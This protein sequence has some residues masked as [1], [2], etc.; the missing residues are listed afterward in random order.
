MNIKNRIFLAKILNTELKYQYLKNTP[1]FQKND[2]LSMELARKFLIN[3]VR[4]SIFINTFFYGII[5][6]MF[7]L[8]MIREISLISTGSFTLFLLLLILAV[9]N[10]S[11]FYRGLWDMKLLAPLSSLPIKVERSVVPLSLFLYNES[12][13]PFVTIPAGIIITMELRNPLPLILYS[14]FT[15]LFLYMGRTISLLLGL[16]FAKTNTNKRSK[17]MYLGQIFQVVIFVIFIM[18]IQISTNPEFLGAI[19]VPVYAFLLIPLTYANL[20]VFNPYPFLIFFIL[21]SLI[22]SLYT[23]FQKKN[24]DENSNVY[25]AIEKKESRQTMKTRKPI[26]SWMVK[27][28]RIILRRRGSI[29]ILVI[30][31]TF[32]IPMIMSIST[33]SSGISQYEFSF[34]Y[35]SSIFLV[36]FILLIGLEGKSA[37]HLSALPVSRRDFFFSKVTLITIIGIF[38]YLIIVII[39]AFYSR[40]S[41]T[42][43]VLNFPYFI[44]ILLTVLMAGGA[45][46]ISAIPK[47]VYT[48]SQE[49]IGGRWILLKT[50]A[51]SL[52][53]IIINA[54]I[55]GF[56]GGYFSG[57]PSII[58]GY[59]FTIIFD[60]IISILFL[61]IFLKRGDYF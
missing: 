57:I 52:P 48:L 24:F 28:F 2:K 19:H 26:L 27:D 35:L 33:I 18:A 34:P 23:Y 54:L 50:F 41:L 55:F 47:E 46:I 5:S 45:Y 17:R 8:A 40:G 32:I 59:P 44:L 25:N 49:G 29:M 60:T 10:D 58:S 9:M 61:R 56:S 6:M 21:F 11:Q 22:Y 12:Y 53:L 51:I 43:M 1:R 4:S 30:P 16:S 14:I 7:G 37:W 36:D 3:N 38:Y 39:M 31:I 13:L 20:T 42:F 15:I